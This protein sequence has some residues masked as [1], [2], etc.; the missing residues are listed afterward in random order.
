MPL[1]SG[2]KIETFITS[3]FST[4]QYG[5]IQPT[6]KRTQTSSQ[7]RHEQDT[8]TAS[9]PP[10]RRDSTRQRTTPH[11]RRTSIQRRILNV[12]I[13][14]R[15]NDTTIT[16]QSNLRPRT[17][18]SSHPRNR[19]ETTTSQ[20]AQRNTTRRTSKKNTLR[21]RRQT[22]KPTP[23]TLKTRTPRKLRRQPHKTNKTRKMVQKTPRTRLDRMGNRKR[24]LKNN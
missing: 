22:T 16:R 4:A 14:H 3:P 20:R 10:Q 21:P 17:P 11:S 9:I 23:T 2:Y 18:T 15:K 24:L 1:L 5:T 12:R 19:M 13:H 7:H 6:R 8:A